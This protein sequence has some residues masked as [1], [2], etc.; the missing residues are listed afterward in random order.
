[1]IC[2]RTFWLSGIEGVLAIGEITEAQSGAERTPLMK[3]LAAFLRT[4]IPADPWQLVFLV[5]A[6]FLLISP[7]LFG[8]LEQ[9]LSAPAAPNIP[10]ELLD[11]NLLMISF[12]VCGVLT[13]FAAFAALFLCFRPGTRPVRWIMWTVL[14]P[15]VVSFC[16]LHWELFRSRLGNPSLFESRNM[17]ALFVQWFRFHIWDLPTGSYFAAT[18]SSADHNFRLPGWYPC[19]F[20]A[21][22]SAWRFRD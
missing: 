7:R 2:S 1:M 15:S 12:S 17:V 18:R 20:I 6:V 5:G 3:R 22:C 10:D 21:N 8:G 16:F 11:R 19:E 4:V 14:F 13:T 9:L